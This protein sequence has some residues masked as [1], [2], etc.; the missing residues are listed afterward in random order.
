MRSH[1]ILYFVISII[2]W[3][4]LL[5]VTQLVQSSSEIHA[6]TTTF[7]Y[8]TIYSQDYHFSGFSEKNNNSVDQ[9]LK[10]MSS[11]RFLLGANFHGASLVAQMVKNLPAIRE[12][13]VQ[14]LV[15]KIPWRGETATHSSI[16]A[17][18]I[19]G[20][21]EPGGLHSMGSQRVEHNWA[22]NTTWRCWHYRV[23]IFPLAML[24]SL[25]DLSSPRRA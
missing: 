16:L 11:P 5:M 9:F 2:L 25:W 19:P 18:R 21:E 15:R 7:H 23:F 17:W 3:G 1:E 6:L 20:T 22:T 10:H 24:H 14:S 12:T 13:W 4:S 8:L